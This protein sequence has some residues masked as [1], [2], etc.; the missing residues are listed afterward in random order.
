M[1]NGSKIDNAYL[2][3]SKVKISG[4]DVSLG[5]EI[6][7]AALRTGLGLDDL[8]AWYNK[9][10]VAFGKNADGTYF[11]DGDFLTNGQFAAAK[12]GTAGSGGGVMLLTTWPTTSGDYSGYALG[13]NLGVELNTRVRTLEGKTITWSEINGK[14]NF[15]SV[16]TSGSYNDLS[17]KPTIPS[18]VT[19]STVSGWGFTKNTGTYSK[20]SGGIPK[21]D[22][23]S[24]VQTSL[25][26]A[27]SSVQP[28]DI[29]E[30][31]TI[32]DVAVVATSGSYN[33][34]VDKPTIPSEVTEDTVSGWGFTKNIGTITGI[35][36]NGVSK[37]NSGVIDLGNVITAH[38][39]ISGKVSRGELAPV[40]FSGEYGELDGIPSSLPASDVYAWAK[41]AN[42]PS[43]S[44]SEIDGT[45]TALSQFTNDLGLGDLAYRNDIDEELVE[46]ALGFSPFNAASFNKTNIKNTLGISDWALES[47]KP[48]YTKSDVGL[49]NVENKSSATIRSEI[50]SDNVTKALGYTPYNATNPSG[51]ITA[52][53]LSDYLPLSGGTLNSGASDT[54][55]VV[56]STASTT[57]IKFESGDNAS[58]YFGIGN[59]NSL[60]YLNDSGAF[61]LY[62]TGNFTPSDYLPLSGGIMSGSITVGAT[63]NTSWMP[64]V[65]N[66]NGN[67]GFIGSNGSAIE[68]GDNNGYLQ[69][70]KDVLRFVN[71]GSG[72]TIYHSGNFNPSDYLHIGGGTINGSLTVTGYIV[73]R[74]HFLFALDNDNADWYVTDRNW[75][76]QYAI[77]HSGNIGSQSV[78][79]A[80]NAG[81]AATVGGY[82]PSYGSNSPWG[83]I[84]V[85]TYG[86]WMDVGKSFEFHYDNETGSDYSTVLACTGNYGNIVDL[87]SASGTLA[88]T[89]QLADYLPKSGGMMQGGISWSMEASSAWENYYDIGGN[90]GLRILNTTGTSVDGAPSAYSV[91]LIVSGYYG[92][93]LA[94]D[95]SEGKVKFK[96]VGQPS[97]K[98][99]AFTD[100]NVASAQSLVHSNGA[101][102]ATVTAGGN[103]LINTEGLGHSYGKLQVKGYE[104]WGGIFYTDRSAVMLSHIGGYGTLVT[105]KNHNLGTYVFR[106]NYNDSFLTGSGNTAL[107][108]RDNGN[109][110]IGTTSDNGAKLQVVSSSANTLSLYRTTGG[111]GSFID[112]HANND[113]SNQWRV[114]HNYGNAGS[115]FVFN[116]F[117][118]ATESTLMSLLDNGNVGIGTSNP[119]WTLDVLGNASAT[120]FRLRDYSTAGLF[121]NYYITSNGYSTDLWL[122]NNERLMI[123]GSTVELASNVNAHG[124]MNVNGSITIGGIRIYAENGVLKIDG[125]LYTSGQFASGTAAN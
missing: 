63:S 87:P 102:G 31:I 69:V 39:D 18:E 85:I 118:G 11:V 96:G 89:S 107:D 122:Y 110:L 30:F 14:P 125:D 113:T 106:V 101:V 5:A 88:L 84:P 29:S 58:R 93:G 60:L 66:R 108:V 79:Y 119:E 76:H 52:S 6:T 24:A 92:F 3:N 12:A 8:I 103:V 57:W 94:Y 27:D 98:T 47:S 75:Q 97:W 53:A 16:A 115:S 50:T 90:R 46:K 54:P 120:V 100:S 9:V 10:G 64:I 36:M 68:M 44:W 112:Y 20:P 35:K 123:Y 4:V 17:N 95:A 62:H 40:A 109:V 43:Y 71:N 19:E 72:N 117:N 82:A 80:T 49:G 32:E 105:S 74:G 86:G 116:K 59:S 81:N 51:F 77:I 61:S 114:G 38:Q 33:D 70:G 7:Q 22:L 83:T 1:W 25:G 48:S 15:A 34:L 41:E 45:P 23:A 65:F 26:K 21:S 121:P 111:G 37:G 104:E 91:G 56:K 78:N 2:A 28:N 13:G 73:N 67:Q 124:N 99:I 42:K 55:L